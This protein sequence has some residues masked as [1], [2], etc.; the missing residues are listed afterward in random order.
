[1]TEKQQKNVFAK[2][3]QYET[4]IQKTIS[5]LQGMCLGFSE[6][7]VDKTG[8]VRVTKVFTKA[9]ALLDDIG[10]NLVEIEDI[11]EDNYVD[12]LEKK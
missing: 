8:Y 5:M 4:K 12:F 3:K 6:G 9:D 1:M 10:S 7:L 11:I 2:I